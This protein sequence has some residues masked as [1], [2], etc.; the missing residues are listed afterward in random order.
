[1]TE[2]GKSGD[3]GDGRDGDDGDD[4]IDSELDHE[5][6]GGLLLQELSQLRADRLDVALDDP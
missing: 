3:D 4:G 6:H 2:I 5:P 1:M